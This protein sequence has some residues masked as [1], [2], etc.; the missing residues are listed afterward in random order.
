MIQSDDKMKGSI[1]QAHELTTQTKLH[2]KFANFL[3][4]KTFLKLHSIS[5]MYGFSQT[6]SQSSSS[7]KGVYC[8]L[9]L[10]ILIG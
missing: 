4:T 3:M 7:C 10:Q 1:S 9:F 5:Y 6:L 2:F 8:M